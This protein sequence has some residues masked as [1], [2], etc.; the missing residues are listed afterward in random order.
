MPAKAYLLKVLSYLP[1]NDYVQD[2]DRG[3]P[4][5]ETVHCIPGEID[6]PGNL[7]LPNKGARVLFIKAL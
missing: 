2:L 7:I 6:P 3:S 4:C 5:T 1:D